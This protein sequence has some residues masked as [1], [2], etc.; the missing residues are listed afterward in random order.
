MTRWTQGD[1]QVDTDPARLDLAVI[2]DFLRTSYWARNVPFEVVERACRHSICFGLHH[3]GGQVGFARAVSDRARFAWLADVFVLP[4]HRGRGL[5]RFLVGCAL[6]HPELRGLRWLLGTRDAHGL[7]TR[8]GF[9]PLAEPAR[10]M[11]IPHAPYPEADP[12]RE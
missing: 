1:Y 6:T 10:F 8:L 4:E 5:A 7:Y 11:E 9:R 2:H 3:A 12:E